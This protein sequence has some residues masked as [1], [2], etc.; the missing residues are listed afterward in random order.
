MNKKL[1]EKG[2][3][4]LFVIISIVFILIVL[5]QIYLKKS[6]DAKAQDERIR[7]I[8]KIYKESIDFDDIYEKNYKNKTSD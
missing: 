6:N 2:S 8:Q 5:I 3:I 4:V 7:Q 1:R